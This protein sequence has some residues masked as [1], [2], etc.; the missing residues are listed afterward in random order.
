MLNI[1]SFIWWY[2]LHSGWYII[3]LSRTFY[4]QFQFL[5][6]FLFILLFYFI[7]HT[8]CLQIVLWGKKNEENIIPE[9]SS[10]SWLKSFWISFYLLFHILLMLPI[11]CC[12]IFLFRTFR[13][14]QTSSSYLRPYILWNYYILIHLVCNFSRTN[15]I[16]LTLDLLNNLTCKM[17]MNL[18]EMVHMTSILA[19]LC[20][21]VL[22]SSLRKFI[23]STFSLGPLPPLM[24]KLLSFP[25]QVKTWKLGLSKCLCTNNFSFS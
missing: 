24:T 19:R 14:L 21:S 16:T 23:M 4:I 25:L 12:C 11:G 17:V 15:T 10:F 9:L 18:K 5:F 22:T 20:Y 2:I 3:T 7:L 6:F 13:L 1:F 8:F